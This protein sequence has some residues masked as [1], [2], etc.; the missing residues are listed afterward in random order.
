MFSRIPDLIR[1]P[2][3]AHLT[4]IPAGEEFSNLS[5]IILED[6]FY[7][8]VMENRQIKDDYSLLN[9]PGIICLKA[10][11]YFDLT[12]RKE[13]GDEVSDRDIRKHR[14]DIFRLVTLLTKSEK[15]NLPDTIK[16]ILNNF[17]RDLENNPPD[18][19]S[20]KKDLKKKG[21]EANLSDSYVIE[22]L[23]DAFEL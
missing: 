22:R 11:A 13:K 8:F 10:K 19:K 17:L 21:I 4:H 12:M 9:T 7:K 2:E 18:Y 5:A 16:T 14:N 23:S 1:I 3:D 6:E 15:I 20:L